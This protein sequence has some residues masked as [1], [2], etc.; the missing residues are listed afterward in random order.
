[1]LTCDKVTDAPGLTPDDV[2]D[3]PP[4]CEITVM[5][6]A[7]E[8]VT[9]SIEAQPVRQELLLFASYVARLDV[10]I[11]LPPAMDNVITPLRLMVFA[12]CVPAPKPNTLSAESP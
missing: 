3:F 4:A 8:F 5:L 7:T 11:N 1:M 10:P 6:L 12:C 9:R 2:I